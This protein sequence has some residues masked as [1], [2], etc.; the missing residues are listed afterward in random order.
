MASQE[1]FTGRPSSTLRERTAPQEHFIDPC[2]LLVEPTPVEADP[3]GEARQSLTER[4]SASLATVAKALRERGH[5]LR[6][7]RH[8]DNRIVVYMFADALGPLRPGWLADSTK[9]ARVCSA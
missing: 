4:A 3:C 8:F 7:G 2:R 9:T 5:E 1:S 6:T